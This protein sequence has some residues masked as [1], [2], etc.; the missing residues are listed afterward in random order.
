MSTPA[1]FGLK[2]LHILAMTLW[3]GGPPVAVFGVREAFGLGPD[4]AGAAA[5]RLIRITP[6]FVGSALVTVLTGGVLVLTAGGLSRAPAR[7][8]VG[9][10]LVV[11]VFVIGGTVVRPTLMKLREHFREGGGPSEAEPLVRRLIWTHRIE[12]LLR[13][14]ILA[15]MVLPL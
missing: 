6:M 4:V 14:T 10:A 11:P 7:V 9:A 8:L 5:D 1:Y 13:V 12:A 3:V 2:L 15:L